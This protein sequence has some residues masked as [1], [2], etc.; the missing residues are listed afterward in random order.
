MP[1]RRKASRFSA[2]SIYCDSSC[3]ALCRASR[4]GTHGHAKRSEMAG[5]SPAMTRHVARALSIEVETC[6]R[7]GGTTARRAAAA[8]SGSLRRFEIELADHGAPLLLVRLDVGLH[9]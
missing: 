1:I 4:S 2:F 5:T 6:I 9:V 8:P 3:P 7:N